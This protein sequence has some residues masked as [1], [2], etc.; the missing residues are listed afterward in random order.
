MKN[1]Y[2]SGRLFEQMSK[3]WPFSL[4]NDEQTSKWPGVVHLPDDI[5]FSNIA[6]AKASV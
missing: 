2:I 1:I 6:L 4:L 3:R 5:Y